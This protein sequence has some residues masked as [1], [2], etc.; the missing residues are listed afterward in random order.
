MAA[1]SADT[2]LRQWY[3]SVRDGDPQLH[4]QPD[5]GPTYWHGHRSFVCVEPACSDTDTDP[6][7]H[8]GSDSDQWVLDGRF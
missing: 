3:P 8:A 1:R 2:G 7:S 4:Q 5:S 6:D